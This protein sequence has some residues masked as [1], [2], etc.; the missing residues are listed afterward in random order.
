MCLPPYGGRGQVRTHRTS[1]VM[2]RYRPA[3]PRYAVTPNSFRSMRVLAG[4]EPS[5]P[6]R[7]LLDR[8]GD[9]HGDIA[10][11]QRAG[12]GQAVHTL[13]T[14]RDDRVPIGVEE[15]LRTDLVVPL[16]VPGAEAR[17]IDLPEGARVVERFI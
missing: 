17:G 6:R 12:Q 9:R 16:P 4:I 14:E 8:Q 7:G 1:M 10:H 11:G 3:I 2:S 5:R 15:A 13:R